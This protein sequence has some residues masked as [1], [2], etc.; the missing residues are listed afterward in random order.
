MLR[1]ELDG[2]DI[3]QVGR[4]GDDHDDHSRFTQFGKL[5]F[6]DEGAVAVSHHHNRTFAPTVERVLNCWNS[7]GPLCQSGDA[8]D[9]P[10]MENHTLSVVEW[11]PASIGWPKTGWLAQAVTD[12]MSAALFSSRLTFNVA[13]TIHSLRVATGQQDAATEYAGMDELWL[14]FAETAASEPQVTQTLGNS[15]TY[16]PSICPHDGPMS[17]VIPIGTGGWF[18]AVSPNVSATQLY[19]N[20]GNPVNLTLYNP[21]ARP[22]GWLSLSDVGTAGKS[23]KPGDTFSWRMFSVSVDVKTNL[24]STADLV[25]LRRYLSS[26]EGLAVLRGKQVDHNG[27]LLELAPEQPALVAELSVPRPSPA[28]NP[29]GEALLLPLRVGP[30]PPRWTVGLFQ[31]AGYTAGHYGNGTDRYTTLGLD[32]DGFAHVPLYAARAPLTHV[33]VGCPVTATGAGAES[34][35]IQVVHVDDSPQTW[36]VEINNPLERA[37][38]VHVS[39]GLGLPGFPAVGASDVRIEAGGIWVP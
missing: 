31:A 1:T 38:T 39:S 27:S 6:S 5:L 4:Q 21:N 25:Q 13:T 12:G 14:V 36:H 35:F 9:K 24:N 11:Y 22:W 15:T 18:G 7:Q 29:T 26:P 17:C 20:L 16:K 33:R 30:F 37:V 34:L 23:V 2:G 28:S 19:F 10:P 3:C 32:G 8:D